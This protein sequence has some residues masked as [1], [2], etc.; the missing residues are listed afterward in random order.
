M[1]NKQLIDKVFDIA[2]L[3]GAAIL[4]IYQ[5]G[6]FGETAKAD[7]SPL[8]KADLASHRMIVEGL[9]RETPD[10]PV[11][12]E[13]AADISF[14][15]R[16]QWQRFWL[17]DPLDGTKEFIKRNG[18]FTVNIALVENGQPVL[19]VVYAPV[20]DVGYLGQNGSEAYVV[21]NSQPAQTIA[22]KLPVPGEPVKVVASRSHSD[23][24]TEQL[25]A[26]LGDYTCVSMGSSLKLCLVA[27]GKANFYPR[28]GP[29]MEWDT[30]AAH[31]VVRA[32]GGRVC[33]LKGVELRY[34]KQDLHNPEFLVLPSGDDGMLSRLGLS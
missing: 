7:Q 3:A 8:T 28:L 9:A 24:R 26:R 23:A 33:D 21:R 5:N 11:L 6:D 18:E 4:D 19:G 27:E 31:A 34:N 10:I 16:S 12:S 25:L 2:R 1:E 32:A 30:A 22:V 15:E 29:T 20:L 13:E 17:V 14:P